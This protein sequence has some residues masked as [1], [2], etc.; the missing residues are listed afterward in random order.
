MSRRLHKDGWRSKWAITQTVC[1][2]SLVIRQPVRACSSAL[3]SRRA[4]R[5]TRPMLET[6]SVSTSS[7]PSSLM[8]SRMTTPALELNHRLDQAAARDLFRKRLSG[9]Y[10]IGGYRANGLCIELVLMPG[11]VDY[12]PVCAGDRSQCH[13]IHGQKPLQH[14]FQFVHDF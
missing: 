3:R 9:T 11:A 12:Q 5:R 10:R 8:G 6:S 4:T 13:S 2:L 1:G 7:T 14:A